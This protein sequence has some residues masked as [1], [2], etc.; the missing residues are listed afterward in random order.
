[1]TKNP[2]KVAF[3][4]CANL[5]WE[6]LDELLIADGILVDMVFTLDAESARKASD[7]R[8]MD[9]LQQ[10]AGF[11]LY[12]VKRG[13][14]NND[15]NLTRILEAKPDIL[16]CIG[17]PELVSSDALS[18]PTMG[19]I[20]MHP[21]KLPKDRG[22]APIPWSI[23][24]G[25]TKS[26]L[27]CF[28]L[29]EKEDA[30]DLLEQIEY[31]I[32]ERDD[33]TKVYSKV[34]DA[35][36]EII[37]RLVPRILA[38]NLKGTKQNEI[39]ATYTRKRSP[40]DGLIDWTRSTLE[41]DRLIRALIYPYYPGAFTYSRESNDYKKI[42]VWK[43]RPYEPS[44]RFYGIPGQVQATPRDGPVIKTGNGLLQLLE[45]G[46]DERKIMSANQ[47]NLSKNQRLGIN[48]AER[49]LELEAE[50]ASLK[51]SRTK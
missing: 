28:R 44:D 47:L 3:I 10:T 37:R 21:S 14:I 50:L 22:Q 13:T 31:P 34:I 49:I 16:F 45:V 23:I 29:V 46:T 40:I 7:F 43:A 17:W 19:G 48:L 27:S 25:Y 11:T 4:G 39:E 35:G 18:I 32:G 41:I 24:R 26:A 2:V 42:L 38:R 6:C 8:H 1:M 20:G 36:R 5:S 15:E 30:G 12:K 33:S 51:S 9:T